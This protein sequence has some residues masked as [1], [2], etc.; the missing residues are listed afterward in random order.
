MGSGYDSIRKA[1]CTVSGLGYSPVAPGTVGSLPAVVIFVVIAGAAPPQFQT[2][3]IAACFA[4]TAALNVVLGSWAERYWQRKDPKEFV[5]DEV[6]GFFLTV[7]L[8]RGPDILLTAV[9]SFVATRLFDII[10]TPPARTLEKLPA[11]WGIL[12]DDLVASL[13]AAA[14][15]HLALRYFPYAFGF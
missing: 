9:W 2:L 15:L 3:L 11:G 13:Y 7:L 8:F 14:S 12:L 5:L 4:A 1:V 6:A 10:K